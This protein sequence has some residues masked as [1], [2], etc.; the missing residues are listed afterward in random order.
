MALQKVHLVHVKS[1]HISMMH[2]F[3]IIIL[4]VHLPVT[5]VI[6]LSVSKCVVHD[7]AELCF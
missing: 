7:T 3:A 4:S 2:T 5:L 6:Q 1:T